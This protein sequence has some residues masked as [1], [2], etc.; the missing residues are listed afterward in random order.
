M[1]FNRFT[2]VL[3][4]NFTDRVPSSTPNNIT[5]STIR[6]EVNWLSGDIPPALQRARD[7]NMLTGN[8]FACGLGG[9]GLLPHDHASAD[10]SCGSNALDVPVYFWMFIATV[11]VVMVGIC[12]LVYQGVVSGVSDTEEWVKRNVFLLLGWIAVT[13]LAPTNAQQ[14][15]PR[16]E[17]SLGAAGRL[18]A[19]V[20]TL[21][22]YCCAYGAAAP[23]HGLRRIRRHIHAPLRM[24]GLGQLS[25]RLDGLRTAVCRTS[26]FSLRL[27][28]SVHPST[29]FAGDKE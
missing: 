20:R 7:V 9:E 12:W 4:G 28:A 8:M 24:D 5:E 6:L 23:L 21:A 11:V 22:A 16:L 2:G 15:N 29:V 10:Y 14:S 3:G 19:A 1:S 26:R 17:L 18:Q 27:G 25:G 13:A